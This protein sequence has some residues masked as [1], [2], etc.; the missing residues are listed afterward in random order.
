[1][2]RDIIQ[3]QQWLTDLSAT[4]GLDGLD[5]GFAEAE[6]SYESFLQGLE[7]FDQSVQT[8]TATAEESAAA[9]EELSS[10]AAHLKQMLQHFKKPFAQQ[11][12]A[13]PKTAARAATTT[14]KPQ[15]LGWS[16]IEQSANVAIKLD[17][18]EFGKF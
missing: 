10:Q 15:G 11:P 2:S 18:N 7:H 14:S 17:D 6:A 5:D 1:M 12:A 3:V 8:N 4:R 13:T 9:A 16:G